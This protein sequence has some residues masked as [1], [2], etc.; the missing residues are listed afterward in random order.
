MSENDNRPVSPYDSGSPSEPPQ[1]FRLDEGFSEPVYGEQEPSAAPNP[2]P[3]PE[4]TPETTVEPTAAPTPEPTAERAAEAAAAS[5]PDPAVA[6]TAALPDQPSQPD[7]A[8]QNPAPVAA[9][10]AESTTDTVVRRTSL[11]TPTE[12][13]VEPEVELPLATPEI[14][15]DSL[16]AGSA[17]DKV[18]SR[19]W[20]HVWS[21]VLT[22][23]LTPITWY[24][25]SDAGARLTLP[26]GNPWDT[27]VLNF[28]ALGELAAG[29]VVL[30]V[31]ILVLRASSLGAFVTGTLL[32][33]AGATFVVVPQLTQ[34][35][36]DP[37]LEGLRGYNDFGANVAHHLVA[38]GSTARILIAGI[39]MIAIGVVSHSARRR[40]R[41]EQRI[42]HSIEQRA[43]VAK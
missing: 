21:V 15:D 14:D 20:S 2:E 29:L 7:T 9:T 35:F 17:Y 4:T 22:L 43:G 42:R 30:F 11:F 26:E 13:A 32:T 19:G 3:T 28:A 5:Q 31:L 37:Y 36:L 8:A 12:A 23:L 41:F 10:P 33:L 25:L 6:A 40:G 18:P 24:L 16:F 34:Q 27:G 38:D 39:A 1:S